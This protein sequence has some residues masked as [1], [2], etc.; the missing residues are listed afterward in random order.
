MSEKRKRYAVVAFDYLE[1]SVVPQNWLFDNDTSCY[2][3]PFCNTAKIAKSI[4]VMVDPLDQGFSTWG[5]Q[6]PRG[7]QEG[8]QGYLDG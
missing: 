4:K 6:T 3:P 1:V 8:F 5:L 2:W 7:S